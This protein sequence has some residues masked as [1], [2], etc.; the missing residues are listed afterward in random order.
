MDTQTQTPAAGSAAPTVPGEQ[1]TRYVAPEVVGGPWCVTLWSGQMSN[2]GYHAAG[3]PCWWTRVGS[4]FLDI[5]RVRGDQCLD[6]DVTVDT[7]GGPVTVAYGVGP[8]DNGVRETVTIHPDGRAEYSSAWRVGDAAAT[9]S[10]R[11]ERP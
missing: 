4:T 1:G 11:A 9:R 6:R 7:T 2:R 3:K 10:H 8:R 5:P